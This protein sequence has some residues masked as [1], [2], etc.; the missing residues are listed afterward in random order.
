MH[1]EQ[2][3]TVARSI[4]YRSFRRR[5]VLPCCALALALVAVVPGTASA[6]GFL[7]KLN[8]L[9]QS[10]PKP[11]AT[12]Q[13]TARTAPSANGATAVNTATSADAPATESATPDSVKALIK[14]T[15]AISAGPFY[16]GMPAD[17]ALAQMK[18]SGLTVNSDNERQPYMFQ[19]RQV[20]NQTYVSGTE[21][22]SAD[23]SRGSEGVEMGF[24]MYPNPS[25]VTYVT[26][27]LRFLPNQGPTVGTTVAALRKK[28]GH[29][30]YTDLTTNKMYWVLDSRGHPWSV[31]KIRDYLH[32]PGHCEDIMGYRPR[33]VAPQVT[34]GIG[35]FAD[36]KNNAAC[37][38]VV[39]IAARINFAVPGSNLSSIRDIDHDY[40]RAYLPGTAA[41]RVWD[42]VANGVIDEMQVDI[43]DHALAVNAAIVSH[44]VAV[45]GLNQQTQQEIE[46]AK[47][48]AAP[49]L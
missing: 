10:L 34:M 22:S 19:V 24:A 18:A 9:V 29:E 26:R 44:D 32:G 12:A 27:V 8:K 11:A 17:K 16:L 25:V 28:Y 46:A 45:H 49:I 15:P 47:K 1:E 38:D 2:K 42:A 20:P 23:T 3:E 6:T 4:R 13:A 40:S 5:N 14:A 37:R 36:V 33:N 39:T 48:R 21:G 30:S 31:D 43:Y 41:D 35:T 7:D